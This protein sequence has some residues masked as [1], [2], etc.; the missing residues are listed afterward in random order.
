VAE[1]A[2]LLD[3]RDEEFTR[4]ITIAYTGM[5]W[6]ETTGLERELLL[7][8]LINV[9]WQLREISGQFYRLP[10]KDDS[11]RSTNWE[12]LLPVDLPPFLATLLTAQAEKYAGRQC[13]CVKEHG[14]SGQYVFL[15]PDGI[16]HYRRSNYSRRVSAQ[17]A[18]GATR[19]Q[20]GRQAS[21]WS[22]TPQPG[23]VS[24][25]RRGR[26]PCPERRSLPR[27]AGG[28]PD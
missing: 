15:G 6:G 7:P 23:Q 22:S 25:P 4:Q 27:Q 24:R 2:A 21:W 20:T 8:T 11:Y 26:R 19:R 10:P 28:P 12:P 14:G 18:T 1:R 9:E 16:H 17:R 5:R 13:G 3:G